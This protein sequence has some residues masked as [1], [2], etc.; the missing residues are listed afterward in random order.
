MMG[1][2]QGPRSVIYNRPRHR[3]TAK[4][5]GIGADPVSLNGT[6]PQ[7][8]QAPAPALLVLLWR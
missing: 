2:F 7:I 5:A 1:L 8:S 6:F 4:G 3:I